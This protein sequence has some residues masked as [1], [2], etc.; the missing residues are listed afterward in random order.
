MHGQLSLYGILYEYVLSVCVS[1]YQVLQNML[2]DYSSGK[3]PTSDHKTDYMVKY[4][5]S[6]SLI[7]RN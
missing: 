3:G 5:F 4:L 6:N 1:F 2:A 7:A